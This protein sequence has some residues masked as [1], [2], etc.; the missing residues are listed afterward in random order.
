GEGDLQAVI[1]IEKVEIVLRNL[2]S[3]ALRHT[4]QGGIALRMEKA[5]KEGFSLTVTDTGSGITPDE[6]ENIFKRFYKGESSTG[7]GLGLAIARE[8]V[9]IMGG[10]I[11]VQS[12]KDKGSSFVVKLPIKPEEARI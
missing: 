6:Q 11:S 10:S 7:V 3:N 9:G 1:D 12:E 5:G 4:E 8:I 2:L